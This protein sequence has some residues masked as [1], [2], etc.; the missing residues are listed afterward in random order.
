[1]KCPICSNQNRIEIDIHSDGYSDNL[2]ECSNCG[3]L[4]INEFG[5]ITLLNNKVA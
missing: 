1:M 2:L 4:W 3:A 5:E